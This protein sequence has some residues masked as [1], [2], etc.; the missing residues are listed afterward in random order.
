MA[1][2]GYA[3]PLFLYFLGVILPSELAVNLFGMALI[4]VRLVLI[5]FFVPA[6]LR[7]MRSRDVRFQAFDA[8][9]LLALVWLA[10]ALIVNNGFERGAKFGGSL[11]LESL[12]GYILARAYVRNG[13]E[14]AYAVGTYF[15]F[16]MVTALIAIPETFLRL[17]FVHDL[18]A[19]ISG[20]PKA[21]IGSEA[22]RLGLARANSTFDHP[23]LYGVFCAS[24]L[25]L[26]WYLQDAGRERWIRAGLLFGAT[27]CAVS[28]APF[29]AFFM[30]AGYIVWERYTRPIPSRVALMVALGVLML[31]A[32]ELLSNRSAVQ[33]LIG[34][35][36]LDHWTAYY[37][38]LIW[39]NAAG[40]IA[41]SPLFGIP[42]NSWTRPQWMTGSVDSFWL[43]TALLGGLPA[44]GFMMAG[45]L[46]L[47]KRVHTWRGPE[48]RA[49]WAARYGW[50][51][52]MLALALQAFTVHYWGSMNSLFFFLVGL[53]AWVTD[54]RDGLV[55]ADTAR[56][57][58]APAE[59]RLLTRRGTAMATLRPR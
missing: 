42:L 53:G 2:R 9:L 51:A 46:I 39:E 12:G 11:L 15:L 14:F 22:G 49:R 44:V 48:T 54:S 59:S 43:N 33:V 40:D 26:V 50:T 29:L 34:I 13:T 37:R 16:V 47:M 17:Q 30:I 19:A 1:D 5:V 10:I 20:L 6:V 56:P 8:F 3:T 58:A 27:F 36:A 57:A 24:A 28:S 45:I 21:V 18:A 41:R 55:T 38:I 7:L 32:I 31:L 23:I 52:T 4:P 25:G 35:V